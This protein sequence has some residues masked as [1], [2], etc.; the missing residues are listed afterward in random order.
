MVLGWGDVWEDLFY[1]QD[2]L[3][4][5][6]YEAYL[7]EIEGGE[8]GFCDDN[9]NNNNDDEDDEAKLAAILDM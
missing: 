5:F 3:A 8:D 2:E 4:E 7:E 1:S 6:R 9:N